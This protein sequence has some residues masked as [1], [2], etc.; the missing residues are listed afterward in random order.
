MELKLDLPDSTAK[1]IQAYHL[2][3]DDE[4]G[5]IETAVIDL[6]DAAVS[7]RIVELV[8]G[9]TVHTGVDWGSP[10]GDVVATQIVR[11]PNPRHVQAAQSF[12]K[13]EAQDPTGMLD[14]LGDEQEDDDLDVTDDPNAAL[15][16]QGVPGGLTD[17]E[18]E[19]DLDVEDPEHEAKVEAPEDTPMESAE[20]MF[21]QVS[22]MP[23][24]PATQPDEFAERRRRRPSR[25]KG[26]VTPL[27]HMPT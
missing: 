6:M 15:A 14:G 17:E 27:N 19:H 10:E 9:Q 11:R 7:Q 4:D 1:K 21:A 24:P 25:S 20:A 12:P 13:V 3:R 16:N 26:R 18:L 22:G 23:V 8:G 5:D 2:L